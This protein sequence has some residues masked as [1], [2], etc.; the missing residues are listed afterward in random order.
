[1]LDEVSQ[2]QTLWSEMGEGE[3]VS[4]SMD[5]TQIM[6]SHVPLIEQHYQAGT[7]RTEDRKRY[8]RLRSRLLALRPEI[9]RL[10]LTPPPDLPD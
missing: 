8:Q 1:M 7:L 4:W 5:W 6:S 3:L 10:Q 2:N 9:S